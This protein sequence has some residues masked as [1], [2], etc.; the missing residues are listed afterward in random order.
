VVPEEELDPEVER[1]LTVLRVKDQQA[2]RQFKIIINRGCETDLY[3]AQGF[4]MLSA[5]LSGAVNGF[6]AVEDAD[7]GKAV[8]SFGEKGSLWKT[9]R[10]LARDF[11]S[12]PA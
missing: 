6:W 4:E 3:P 11:W 8:M 1:L 7:Q 10:A 9:R 12:E 2:C 5:G